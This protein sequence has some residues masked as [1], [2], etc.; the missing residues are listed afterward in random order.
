MAPYFEAR[1]GYGMDLIKKGLKIV[2]KAH[3]KGLLQISPSVRSRRRRT[4]DREY[5]ARQKE[6]I[7]FFEEQ[8]IAIMDSSQTASVKDFRIELAPGRTGSL[9]C[10]KSFRSRG[11]R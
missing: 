8:P 7:L 5:A 2:F 1:I 11:Y 6:Q 4:G 3:P 9:Y 10:T